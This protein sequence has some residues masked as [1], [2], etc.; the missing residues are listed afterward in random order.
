M[1]TKI[2]FNGND[3]IVVSYDEFETIINAV[4]MNW[5][6]LENWTGSDLSSFENKLEG[7]TCEPSQNGMKIWNRNFD[8]SQLAK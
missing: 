6:G 4:G 7:L 5:Y 1:K 2:D 3:H 8:Y